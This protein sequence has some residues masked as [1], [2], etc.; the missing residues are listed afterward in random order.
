MI[1]T[2][3]R[4]ASFWVGWLKKRRVEEIFFRKIAEVNSFYKC[5]RFYERY[6]SS[7]FHMQTRSN[8]G[9]KTVPDTQVLKQIARKKNYRICALFWYPVVVKFQ[10]V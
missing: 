8:V 6:G 3:H 4:Q 2:L 10:T 1:D 7:K 9:K 5:F